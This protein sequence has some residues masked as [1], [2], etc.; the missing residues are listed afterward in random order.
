[1]IAVD[2]A[3]A[4]RKASSEAL[5]RSART[6]VKPYM[7]PAPSERRSSGWRVEAGW[8][9]YIRPVLRSFILALRTLTEI[10]VPF[11]P[12]ISTASRGLAQERFGK[13][14]FDRFPITDKTTSATHGETCSSNKSVWSGC[15]VAPGRQGLLADSYRR[16]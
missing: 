4:L 15:L 3:K 11:L 9:S 10:R 7:D 12:V 8:Q 16:A 6:L 13:R 5:K 14:R 2:A 1:M